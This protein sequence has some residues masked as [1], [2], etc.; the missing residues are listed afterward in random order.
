MK[1]RDV[2]VNDIHPVSITIH[3]LHRKASGN[4]HYD[5]EGYSELSISITDTIQGI[6][7][8]DKQ[9]RTHILKRFTN[10]MSMI[11]KDHP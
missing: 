4:V 1:K 2:Q 5:D 11:R 9:N 10:E 7:K 6:L 3:H 8:K